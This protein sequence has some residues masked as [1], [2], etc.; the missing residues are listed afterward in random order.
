MNLPS[1][2]VL[3]TA[4]AALLAAPAFAEDAKPAAKTKH[5]GRAATLT[6]MTPDQMKWETNPGDSNVK[7]AVVWGDM[8]K[9]PHGA[10]HKFPAGWASPL[11]THSSD[12]KLV[13]VSGTLIQATEGGAELKLPAGSY[14]HQ[15]HAVKHVTKCDAGSECVVFVVASGKFDLIPAD[16]GTAGKK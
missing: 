16:G 15:P 6:T 7:V 1:R 9:G 10:F 11:H 12:M 14:S 8:N 13:V 4:L 3:Y 2:V 5:A